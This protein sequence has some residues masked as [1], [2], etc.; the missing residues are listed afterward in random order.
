MLSLLLGSLNVVALSLDHGGDPGPEPPAVV[1]HEG[2]G[3]G[4]ELLLGGCDERGLGGVGTSVNPRLK[5]AADK[6]VHRI[7]VGA[8]RR[9]HVLGD[10]VVGELLNPRHGPVGHMAGC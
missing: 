1:L 5:I 8:A 7:E 3:H 9:P 6:I 10:A 4:G 2:A